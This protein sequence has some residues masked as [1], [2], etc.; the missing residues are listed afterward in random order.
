VRV[1]PGRELGSLPRASSAAAALTLAILLACARMEPPPGGPPD[2][3]PPQLV[4]T[5]PDSLANVP[6]FRSDV[7]FRFDEVVSE[8]GTPS[9][10]TGTGDLEKLI[11]VSPTTR[12]PHVNWKRDRI[13]VRPVEG[14]RPN[15]VYR[16]EL[17][18]GVTD[19][20]RNQS[21]RGTVLTFTTGG[22]PPGTTIEGTVVDWTTARPAAA[23]LVEA[24]L[25]PDSLDY[26]GLA[27]SSGHVSLGPLPAGTYL[28]RGV[29]D[30]NHNNVFD[31][32][33]A[34]DTVRLSPGKTSA[35]ELWA[36]VHDTTPP[37]IREITVGDSV[38][39]NVAMSQTLDPAQR[40]AQAAVTV[41]I[42]PDSTPVRITS[43]LPKPVD[44]SLHRVAA[45]A[46]DTTADT[47]KKARP[48]AAEAPPRPRVPGA[49]APRGQ[50]EPLTSRPP[51][52]DQLVVRVAQ[53]WRPGAKYEIE[54][55]GVRNT[56]GVKGD[57]RGGFSVPK[58]AA[59]DTTKRAADSTRRAAGKPKSPADTLARPPDSLGR[60]PP[61]KKP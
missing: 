27:D 42:L 36:F 39:A 47:T 4:A 56:T 61:P 53:P 57:V 28:V 6:G 22:A 35:G 45:P 1:T 51:L 52:T 32:R 23:A 13:T 11:I 12:V 25:L 29:I 26:R 49:P 9:Q 8:G 40:L 58:V 2:T 31:P 7:V 18:P 30:Q 37:R 3:A 55:R 21:K 60:R 19:L 14:W 5:T 41:R 17:L 50:P 43:V 46:R 34:F 54:I 33:E 24:L 20:R 48:G 15:R 16:V 59:P 38:S 10:G 44:D